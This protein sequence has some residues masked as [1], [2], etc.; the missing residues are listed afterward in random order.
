M[1]TDLQERTNYIESTLEHALD[2]LQEPAIQE[3]LGR[4]ATIFCAELETAAVAEVRDGVIHLPHDYDYDAEP[5][6]VAAMKADD[7][8]TVADIFDTQT[9]IQKHNTLRAFESWRPLGMSVQEAYEAV[10]CRLGGQAIKPVVTMHKQTAAMTG[11]TVH[12]ND[13]QS[14]NPYFINTP[15][16][17]ITL[18]K[19]R[20]VLF[21]RMRSDEHYAGEDVVVHELVHCRQAQLNPIST[22]KSQRS[23]DMA[24]LRGELE[25]YHVGAPISLELERRLSNEKVESHTLVQIVVEGTR[26]LNELD[27]KDPFKPSG[28]LWSKLQDQ[29]VGTILHGGINYEELVHMCEQ[30]VSLYDAFDD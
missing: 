11:S 18:I 20:P 6:P 10:I 27:P 14:L 28:F 2:M 21:L 16:E 1:S 5:L 15:A 30:G 24:M 12:L 4:W 19:N 13:V 7:R 3:T 26:R 17:G 8:L 29:H 23:A 22:Y 9:K 25:A